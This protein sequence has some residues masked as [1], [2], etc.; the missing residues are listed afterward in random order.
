MKQRPKKTKRFQ[1]FALVE[2]SVQGWNKNIISLVRYREIK[3]PKFGRKH[4]NGDPRKQ[5][6]Q[7]YLLARD[8]RGGVCARR[9][10]GAGMWRFTVLYDEIAARPGE[11]GRRE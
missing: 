7:I 11:T 1:D 2:C 5:G 6:K 3:F 4:G 9:S 10:R 8:T